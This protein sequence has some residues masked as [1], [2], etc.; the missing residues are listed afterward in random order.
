MGECKNGKGQ[1]LTLIMV[2]SIKPPAEC[3]RGRAH[4]PHHQ[5]AKGIL[6]VTHFN[7]VPFGPLPFILK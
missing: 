2:D 1:V 4:F 6:M 7:L 3:A 5:A